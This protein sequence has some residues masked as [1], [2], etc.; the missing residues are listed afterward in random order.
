MDISKRNFYP[1]PNVDT[2]VIKLN[3]KKNIRIDFGKRKAFNSFVNVC[4]SHRRKQLKNNLKGLVEKPEEFLEEYK[5]NPK[6]RAEEL[7]ID[8]FV[9]LFEGYQRV[10]K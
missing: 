8:Q 1:V 4:F 10:V 2:V 9:T 3:F 7:T 5:I 6:I